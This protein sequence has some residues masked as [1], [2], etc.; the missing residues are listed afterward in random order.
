MSEWFFSVVIGEFL[1]S[2]HT[3]FLFFT[4]YLHSEK[5]LKTANRERFDKKNVFRHTM[6]LNLLF[7]TQMMMMTNVCCDDRGMPIMDNVQT[8]FL[9][10]NRNLQKKIPKQH[11]CKTDITIKW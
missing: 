8:R 6:L 10:L 2:S 7:G 1:T 4:F 11:D 9:L 3:N 5:N